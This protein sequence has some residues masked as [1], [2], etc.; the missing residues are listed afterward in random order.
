MK[1]HRECRWCRRI[2]MPHHA[3]TPHSQKGIYQLCAQDHLE[4]FCTWLTCQKIRPL[5]EMLAQIPLYAGLSIRLSFPHNQS[6]DLVLRSIF[7][8]IDA[9][10]T[11]FTT[12]SRQDQLTKCRGKF[13]QFRGL[14]VCCDYL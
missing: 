14:N 13:L 10:E 7:H 12:D 11:A 4:C 3:P 6:S 2:G 1:G 8:D 5:R 9:F